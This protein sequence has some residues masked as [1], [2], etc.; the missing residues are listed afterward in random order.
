MDL[1]ESPV[2]D[3]VSAD[4]EQA[5]KQCEHELL[6]LIRVRMDGL[7]VACISPEDIWQEALAKAVEHWKAHPPTSAAL[8]RVWLRQKV[9]DCLL[10]GRDYFLA[11]MRDARRAGPLPGGSSDQGGSQLAD[12]SS[13][14]SAK[15]SRKEQCDRLL[16]TLAHLKPSYAEILRKHDLEGHKLEDIAR[17]LGES[18]ENIRARHAR[19]FRRLRSLWKQLYGDED[20]KR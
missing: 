7:L 15:V 12:S 6:D 4:L 8:V 17:E 13:A 10:D 14:A 16:T 9:M 20:F 19:A 1:L 2:D 3:R 11:K 5:I 18:Y